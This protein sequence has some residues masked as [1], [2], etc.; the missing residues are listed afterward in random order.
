MRRGRPV[1]QA[2]MR[3]LGVVVPDPLPD[4]HPQFLQSVEELPI[5][6][7]VTQRPIETLAVAVLPGAAWGDEQGLHLQPLQPLAQ[8]RGNELRAV[9]GSDMFRDAT[10]KHHIGQY[11]DHLVR[12][13]ML[14]FYP[15][16]E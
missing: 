5:E 16:P 4:D 11:L 7:L 12:A 10:L 15:R 3:P 1:P 6:Q 13:D 14:D 9:I 8:L 2:R